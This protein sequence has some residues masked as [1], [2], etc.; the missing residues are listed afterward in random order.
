MVAGVLRSQCS[1][2]AL[3]THL[4]LPLHS[5]LSRGF[6]FRHMYSSW[7]PLEILGF[8]SLISS[9]PDDRELLCP[10]SSNKSFQQK[11]HVWTI[12]AHRPILKSTPLARLGHMP[13]SLHELSTGEGGFPQ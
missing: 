2:D 11:F 12:L 5:A 1:N 3:E 9:T 4:H 6:A 13:P 8:Y 7:E 10:K